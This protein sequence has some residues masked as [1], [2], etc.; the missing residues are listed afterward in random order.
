MGSFKIIEQTAA[1]VGFTNI[2]M[3]FAGTMAGVSYTSMAKASQLIGS[4]N[5]TMLK[6]LAWRT[7]LLNFVC[8]QLLYLCLWLFPSTVFSYYS[9]EALVQQKMSLLL[10]PY[11]VMNCFDSLQFMAS[12]FYKAVEMGAWVCVVFFSSYYIAGLGSMLLMGLVV[13]EKVL[14]AWWGF[15]IGLAAADFCFLYRY[16]N[17]DLGQL[18]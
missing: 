1:H 18:V 11:F 16:R 9:D 4:N 5:P 14:C 7:L 8:V 12:Q 3:L 2:S 10:L 15:T 13:E 17:M 6:I